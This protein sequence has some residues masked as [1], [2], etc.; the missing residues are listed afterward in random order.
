MNLQFQTFALIAAGSVI[1]AGLILLIIR[2]MIFPPR[3]SPELPAVG[4]LGGRRWR[5]GGEEEVG[6]K[7]VLVDVWA[8]P[9]GHLE[10]GEGEGEGEGMKGGLETRWQDMMPV[11]A[12]IIV[13]DPT[14]SL[15]PP[16]RSSVSHR[17]PPHVEITL[18]I[19]MP[20]P[21]PYH[22]PKHKLDPS[23][24]DD[25]I[26]DDDSGFEYEEQLVY[27]LGVARIPWKGVGL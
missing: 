13:N 7:P 4:G 14:P 23:H 20:T 11:G 1:A 12:R 17:I 8:G 26:H 27:E 10:D 16:S 6:E 22:I 3:I 25:D 24:D 21:P 9:R 5:G 18:A 2:R 15:S 19:I